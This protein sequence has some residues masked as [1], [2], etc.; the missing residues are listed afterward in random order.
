MSSLNYEEYFKQARNPDFERKVSEAA[1]RAVLEM[2]RLVA[3]EVKLRYITHIFAKTLD[4][5]ADW[6]VKPK[7]VN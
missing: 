1:E 6:L 7:M 2:D 5:I 4:E 3:N